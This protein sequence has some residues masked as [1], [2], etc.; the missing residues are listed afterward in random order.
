M[1]PDA[2]LETVLGHAPEL[3]DLDRCAARREELVVPLRGGV[4]AATYLVKGP[5]G[6]VVVKLNDRGT[7]AEATALRAW[8]QHTTAVPDVLGAGSVR[9]RDGR[10]VG[11]LV[12]SAL[13]NHEGRI[14]ETGTDLLERCPWRA[15]DL[16][17]ALGGELGRMHRAVHTGAVGNFA[18]SPGAE[19]SY[20]TWNAYLEDFLRMHATYLGEIGLGEREVEGACGFIRRCRFV[21]EGRYLH[22]DVSIRNLAV[23]GYAPV[24]ISVFDP[25]PLIGDAS[26]DVAPMVNNVEFNER[27]HGRTPDPPDELVRDREL[28]A[29]FRETYPR[30]MTEDALLTAQLLQAVLQAEHRETGL[31]EGRLSSHD[32]EVTRAFVRDAARRM[33]A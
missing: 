18:D 9:S 24:E 30:Q 20:D 21:E 1:D 26:W 12:L 10:R 31:Q 6:Q 15:R 4:D 13:N 27:R 32:V 5:R 28:L 29:G 19:R 7:E 25:N 16:G 11:Y 8:K 23:H 14:V 33:S 22:G 3:A 17:R 2:D